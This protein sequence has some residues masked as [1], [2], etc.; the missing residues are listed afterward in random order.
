VI[1]STGSERLD[2]L[3]G[4]YETGI[5]TEFFGGTGTGKTTLA[6]YVPI[7]QIYLKHKPLA[8]KQKFIFIDGDGGFDLERAK[9]IWGEHF[10]DIYEHLLY[11]Q[12]TKFEE[13]H[14][15]ITKKLQGFIKE[16]SIKPLF[17]AA[18]SMTAIYRGQVARTANR[19][20]AATIGTLTGKLD[21][22]LVRLRQLAVEY[23]CPCV[24]T[25]WTSSPVGKSL[26]ATAELP[27]IGGRAFG[28]LAKCVVRLDIAETEEGFKRFAVLLKHRSRPLGL[29]TEFEIV[30]EGVK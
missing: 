14:E 19:Y 27:M 4:G 7:K 5:L 25:T 13:Q 23:N 8:E 15:L 24:V 20:K 21:L 26:G 12:P 6:G 3:F 1:Y 17:I 22:Q 10:K 11:Y 28:F 18:D 16:R 9:Q 30:Q 29:S 2:K